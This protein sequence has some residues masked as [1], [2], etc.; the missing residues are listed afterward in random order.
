MQPLSGRLTD[1]FSRR[2]GLVFSNIFFAAGN[3]ICGLAKDE[4]VMILGRV[5]AGMGGG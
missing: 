2:A 1:I 4:W 5:V 3:L